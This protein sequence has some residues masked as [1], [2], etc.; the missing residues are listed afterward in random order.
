MIIEHLSEVIWTGAGVSVASIIAYIISRRKNAAEA[1]NFMTKAAKNLFDTYDK[2]MQDLERRMNIMSEHNIALINQN[3]GLVKLY[4]ELNE[5]Y[6][7]LEKNHA[8]CNRK[9]MELE[10]AVDAW[11]NLAKKHK[12]HFDPN[13]E[14]K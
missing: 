5:K 9:Y 11:R 14:G 3:T 4:S 13:L 6:V 1:D 12:I 10:L 7:Q 8:D 2:Q